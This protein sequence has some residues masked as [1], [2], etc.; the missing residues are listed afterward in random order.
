M[1][2]CQL[3]I[4]YRL[5]VSAILSIYNLTMIILN[6]LPVKM[7]A[8]FLF[9]SIKVIKIWCNWVI[10]MLFVKYIK[11]K[12]KQHHPTIL[13]YRM[14]PT[15]YLIILPYIIIERRVMILLIMISVSS[16]MYWNIVLSIIKIISSKNALH[17]VKLIAEDISMILHVPKALM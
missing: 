14:N 1:M 16:Q 15:T 8:W 17:L 6:S 7:R 2:L 9:T 4:K 12:L 5:D 13:I 11:T 3:W 10:W